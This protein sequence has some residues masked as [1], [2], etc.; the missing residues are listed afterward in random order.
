MLIEY[1]IDIINNTFT[2][3]LF[4]SQTANNSIPKF[5]QPIIFL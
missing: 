1:Q 3:T 5:F 2:F 4:K